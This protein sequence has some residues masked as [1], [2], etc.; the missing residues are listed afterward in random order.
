MNDIG[1][2]SDNEEQNEE[3]GQ[4]IYTLMEEQLKLYFGQ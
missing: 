2:V 3:I 4:K 1:V